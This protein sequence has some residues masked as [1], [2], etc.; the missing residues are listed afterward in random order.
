MQNLPILTVLIFL[1]ILGA[2]PIAF[3]KRSETLLVRT[4]TLLVT[5]VELGLAVGMALSF[6]P[7]VQGPQFVERLSWIPTLGVQYYLGADGISLAMIVLTALLSF[8]AVIG[9][10]AQLDSDRARLF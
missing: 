2:I 6:N 7:G 1:P 3:F 9:S 5:L 10:W 4:W 8:V